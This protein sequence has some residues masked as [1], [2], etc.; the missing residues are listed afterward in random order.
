MSEKK[1]MRQIQSVTGRTDKQRTYQE[2]MQ[3]Y[4]KAI[5]NGFFLEAIMIDY[6]CLEDRLRYMLYHIGVIGSESDYRVA[7]KS[8][9]VRAFREI[10]HE[11]VGPKENMSIMTIRS[12]RQIVRS[13][14][15]LANGIEKPKDDDKRRLLLWNALHDNEHIAE[16]ISILDEI[17]QWCAYRNEIVHSLLN[18][19][20]DSLHERLEQQAVKGYQLFRSLDRQVR[21]VKGKNLREKLGLKP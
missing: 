7:G 17:E 10:L 5:Q 16:A 19:N 13:I 4:K 20:L 18:K 12:K 2:H 21:W 15:L 3:R 9:R 11:Y 14:L 1:A 6:A 8:Q